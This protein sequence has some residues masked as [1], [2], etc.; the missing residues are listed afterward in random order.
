MQNAVSH[1]EN[2]SLAIFVWYRSLRGGGLHENIFDTIHH[3][4]D[5]FKEIVVICPVSQYSERFYAAGARV[6]EVNY[7]NFLFEDVVDEIGNVDL[8][9]VHPGK[10]RIVGLKYAEQKNVP[11]LMTIHGAWFDQL[12]AYESKISYVIAVSRHIE[13]VLRQQ[14]PGLRHRLCTI[15]NGIDSELFDIKANTES[16]ETLLEP[17]VLCVS[18]Y[19]V[20]KQKLIDSMLA[21]WRQQHVNNINIKW[22]IVGDGP[23]LSHIKNTATEIFGNQSPIEFV[24]WK[25][26]E[27][28]PDYYSKAACGY[29]P[30][31]SA[32]EAMSCGLPV[33]AAGCSGGV[34][35]INHINKIHEAAY[36]NFGEFGSENFVDDV[37]QCL[38]FM[39]QCCEGNASLKGTALSQETRK[40]FAA[41]NLSTK[42]IMLYERAIEE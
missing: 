30:G 15:E 4:R 6:V 40:L 27:Y 8:I 16:E 36:S 42:L 38:Q 32:I 17:H 9:H 20:D 14:I 33:I 26:K 22:I 10:S 5:Q 12:S 39:K 23:L 35:I 34:K 24:G 31:R 37:D 29:L 41:N 25:E 21:L 28:L 1:F 13:E 11:V 2:K 19:D 18:R 3:L 7:D